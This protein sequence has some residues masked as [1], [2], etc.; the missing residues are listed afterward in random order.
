MQ[1][2][3]EP[4]RPPNGLAALIATVVLAIVTGV[5]QACT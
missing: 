4:V 3:A 2:P 5:D 1:R